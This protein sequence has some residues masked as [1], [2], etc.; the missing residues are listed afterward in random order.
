MVRKLFFFLLICLLSLS[1]I[2]Q[3]DS[4]SQRRKWL[5]GGANA[6][7]YTSTTILLN[8][9]WYKSFPKSNFHS[10]ND[11]REWLG[12]DK[13]GHSYTAYQ[14][15]ATQYGAWKWAGVPEKKA[16]WLAG[17]ISWGYQF[18]VEVLDGFSAEYGFSW[19]DITANTLGDCLFMGQQLAWKDQRIRLKFGYT[20]SPYAALRPNVLGAN[21]PEKLL[22]DYNAQS[23]WLSTS[24]AS[25]LPE[26]SRFP[27]WLAFSVGYS[28]DAKIKGNENSYTVNDFN[29]RAHPEYALSLDIDWSK[30]PFRKPWLKKLVKPLNALKFPFPSVYWRNG[31]C[32]VGII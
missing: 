19:A 9:V 16:I 29:Y 14:L 21:F 30:I 26:T 17:S 27:R 18:T 4:I 5:V 12:M 1:A 25:F 6:V 31:V 32:Y 8:E 13:I 2:A 20:S 28:I 7:I 10:F 3:S 11:S 24:P 15:T 22:K 23:Y